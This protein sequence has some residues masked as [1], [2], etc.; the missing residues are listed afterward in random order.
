MCVCSQ[1]TS[2]NNNTLECVRRFVQVY[3]GTLGPRG[4]PMVSTIFV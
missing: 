4:N 3:T 2:Y 1:T